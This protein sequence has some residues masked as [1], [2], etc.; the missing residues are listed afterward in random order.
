MFYILENISKSPTTMAT[1]S[2]SQTSQAQQSQLMTILFY[3]MNNLKENSML[4]KLLFINIFLL[5]K[6]Y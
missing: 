6:K 1:F 4:K 5:I 2:K 3:H